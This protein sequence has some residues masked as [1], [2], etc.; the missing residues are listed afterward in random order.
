[1]DKNNTQSALV[2]L[3]NS[4][5]DKI[6]FWDQDVMNCFYDGKY[7]EI[8]KYLNFKDIDIKHVGNGD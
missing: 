6:D 2:E 8:S 3:M 5:Y 1:M 4:I 7:L